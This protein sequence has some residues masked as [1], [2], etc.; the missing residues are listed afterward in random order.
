MSEV[1]GNQVTTDNYFGGCPQCG[2]GSYINVRKSHYGICATHKVYCPIG[3][4]LF[5]SW[6][7][8]N[9]EVWDKNAKMLEGFTE[10]EPI[11]PV[12]DESQL[13]LNSH[14][15]E[16][17]NTTAA[18]TEYQRIVIKCDTVSIKTFCAFCQVD[19][20]EGP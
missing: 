17:A 2:E 18:K 6:Q 15:T 7:E 16:A 5:S 3:C 8:E 1:E 10:V 19:M 14:I 12:M 13:H 4:N 20:R 11:R 9:Q